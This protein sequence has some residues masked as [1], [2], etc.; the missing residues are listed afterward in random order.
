MNLPQTSDST[1]RQ[2]VIK[3]S[4]ASDSESLQNLM[5]SLELV[6]YSGVYVPEPWREP[7]DTTY[8]IVR[9]GNRDTADALRAALGFGEVR[10][11]DEGSF[12]SN[13][14]IDSPVTIVLGKDWLEQQNSTNLSY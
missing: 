1:L 11:Q 3:D 5:R 8:I 7:L 6:G 2:V 14:T 10:V 12:D 13:I 4:T 9:N